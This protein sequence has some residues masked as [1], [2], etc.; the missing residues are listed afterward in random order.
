MKK[1][2]II[3]FISLCFFFASLSFA[4]FVSNGQFSLDGG[5]SSSGGM[6]TSDRYQLKFTQERFNV[7][8]LSG[9]GYSMQPEFLGVIWDSSVSQFIKS[10][11]PNSG[12]NIAPIH[13]TIKGEI[14]SGDPQVKLFK[15]T[16]KDIQGENI[17]VNYSSEVEC[18][19]NIAGAVSG[20][21]DIFVSDEVTSG[22]LS[23]AFEVKSYSYGSSTII[24]S[25]NPF[26]PARETT[27][28]MYKLDKDIN[29]TVVIFSS[30]GDA[31]WKRNYS[32]GV[33]GGRSGD[34]NIVWD[35][36]T[37]FGELASNGVFLVHVIDLSAN[38]TL[39]RGKIAV[40]RR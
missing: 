29:V 35:G 21:W 25:P 4:D 16:E 27:N 32:S 12:Y 40:I 37:A 34:N 20:F 28:I 30:T 1:I 22:S 7:G 39:A 18:D 17:V 24:N 9:Q 33:N 14:F 36:I 26:D 15:S 13:V 3:L 38:K 5:L 19:F 8:A 6:V 2:Y 11:E 10:I 23:N 31:L